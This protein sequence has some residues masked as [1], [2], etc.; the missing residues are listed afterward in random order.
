M[1]HSL[2]VRPFLYAGTKTALIGAGTAKSGTACFRKPVPGS[3]RKMET[4]L[5]A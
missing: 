4:E 5:V 3:I 2:E 1:F